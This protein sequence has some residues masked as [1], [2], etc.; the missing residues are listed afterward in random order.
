VTGF[1]ELVQF[2]VRVTLHFDRLRV[3]AS[4]V[5][6]AKARDRAPATG[7]RKAFAQVRTGRETVDLVDLMIGL[8]QLHALAGQA[9]VQTT[10]PGPS[11]R[12]TETSCST[13]PVAFVT[14]NKC[15]IGATISAVPSSTIGA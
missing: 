2:Q 13:C 14:A 15:G 1:L 10:S 4:E 5:D 12:P 7:P 9:I 3:L 8:V 6:P 11:D